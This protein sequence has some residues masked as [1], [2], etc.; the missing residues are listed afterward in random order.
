[1]DEGASVLS[2]M[3]PDGRVSQSSINDGVIRFSL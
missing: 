2:M 1:M 3:D